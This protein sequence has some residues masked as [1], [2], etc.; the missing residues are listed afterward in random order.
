ELA[1]R[2][3]PPSRTISTRGGYDLLRRVRHRVAPHHSYDI[4]L[5]ESAVPS[6]A[7]GCGVIF[8]PG[9]SAIWPVTTTGSSGFTPFSITVRSPCWRCPGVT[10]RSSTVLSDFTTNTK[11]PA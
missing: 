7:Y 5:F 8:A 9:D 6:G 4:A 3:T 2:T 1:L 10:G 11:G